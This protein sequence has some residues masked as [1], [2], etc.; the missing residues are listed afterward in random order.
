MQRADF[1]HITRWVN[2]D[3]VISE[4]ATSEIVK[5]KIGKNEMASRKMLNNEIAKI[6]QRQNKAVRPVQSRIHVPHM[7]LSH[8]MAEMPTSDAVLFRL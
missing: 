6:K 4:M 2:I 5:S 3:L 8:A 1:K 7:L